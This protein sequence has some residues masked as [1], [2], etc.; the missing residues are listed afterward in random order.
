[1]THEA[2]PVEF[3]YASWF[4]R[5]GAWIIDGIPTSM[6]FGVLLVAFGES[7]ATANGMYFT[8]NGET[9]SLG[10]W[11]TL[12]FIA[13]SLAWFVYNWMIRQGGTGQT[14]GKKIVGIGVFKANTAEPLG[15]GLTLARQLSHI[16]DALPCGLG[17]LWPIWDKQKRTFADMMIGSRA[18]RV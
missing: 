4:A 12:V 10:G 9:F 5:V 11:P 16:I 1:M 13:G 18:Y 8:A 2:P 3:A 17:Y 15:A 14:V 6:L 7:S